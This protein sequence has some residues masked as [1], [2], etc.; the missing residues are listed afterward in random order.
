MTPRLAA[1]GG[2]LPLVLL[3]LAGL[4]VLDAWQQADLAVLWLLP[5]A[6]CG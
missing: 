2:W 4:A 1:R 6:I 5:G 3:L